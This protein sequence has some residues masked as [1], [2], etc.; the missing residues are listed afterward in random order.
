MKKLSK[1]FLLG[2]LVLPCLM[3]YAC[4]T[5][6]VKGRDFEYDN[7]TVDFTGT[8]TANQTAL[9][10]EKQ[11]LKDKYKDVSVKFADN[12]TVIFGSDQLYYTQDGSKITMFTDSEKKNAYTKFNGGDVQ[13]CVD[14]KNVK[15]TFVG[16]EA[17]NNANYKYTVNF[18]QVASDNTNK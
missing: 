10:N 5:M 6:S 12:G 17:N 4:G 2:V 18:K 1:L 3:L 15:V 16:N 9:E 14:G 7:S 8:G 13:I 11:S